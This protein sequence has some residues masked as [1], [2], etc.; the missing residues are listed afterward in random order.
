M[1]FLVGEDKI[2]VSSDVITYSDLME[3]ISLSE[4]NDIDVKGSFKYIDGE[5]HI[6]TTT[7]ETEC[8]ELHDMVNGTLLSD[9]VTI[10][11]MYAQGRVEKI[12]YSSTKHFDVIA[13]AE[14][15]ESI[16]F[17]DPEVELV[18]VNGTIDENV[19]TPLINDVNNI[20]FVTKN[21]NMVEENE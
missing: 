16:F 8:V 19:Q 21:T 11:V 5:L 7:G 14:R 13:N 9:L 6:I 17:N 18:S 12:Y 1:K 2:V 15:I 20:T 4:D 3:V 10:E